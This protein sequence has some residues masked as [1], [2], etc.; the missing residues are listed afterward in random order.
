MNQSI[1]NNLP[2][3]QIQREIEKLEKNNKK[4]EQ[5]VRNLETKSLQVLNLYFVFQGV[6]LTS[7]S[8]SSSLRCHNW[9]I[10]FSLSLLAATLNLYA[11]VDNV[12]KILKSKEEIDQAKADL[13]LVRLYRMTKAQIS[14]VLPGTRLNQPGTEE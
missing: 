6:I 7:V 11:L 8:N 9:W 10:P 12:S 1:G 2:E 3:D 5:R 4:Q 14:Q 13:G